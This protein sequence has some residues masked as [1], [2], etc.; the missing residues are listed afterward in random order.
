MLVVFQ[1]S[2]SALLLISTGLIYRQVDHMR[3]L[4]LG[5]NKDHLIYMSLRF[6]TA[7]TYPVFKRE[8]QGDA[9]IPGV[10][11]AFQ[12]P[13]NNRMKETGTRWDGWNPEANSYVF[14]DAVD[15]DYAET[16]GLEL[17]AGRP[18]SEQFASDLAGAFLVNQTMLKQMDTISAEEAVGK[19]LSSWG[20]T[21]PI[22]GVLKDYHFQNARS[23]IEPQVISLGQDKL[24]YAVI[25][26][27][28]GR[29]QNSLDRVK[30]AW[31]KVNPGHPFEYRFFDEAFDVMYRSDQLL[32]TILRSFALMG[33]LIACIGLFGLASFTAAQRSREIGVRRVLGA[34]I[35]GLA[36]RMAR[37]F[38]VWVAAANVLAWPL[39]F[40]VTD[41][42]LRNCA[43][44]PG[45]GWWMFPAAAAGSIGAALLTVGFQT[46]RAARADPVRALKYE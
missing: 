13:M 43:H 17:A 18:F 30:S 37:E 40:L 21:G 1:F 24:R 10:T 36:I 19:M 11:A 45:F 44:R 35:T 8:L 7:K 22:V 33:V 31:Q 27:Q 28:G 42:W 12:L 34:S 16:L 5:Y 3:T 38:I 15:F 39:A 20:T 4:D 2:L 46:V 6:D 14:Y 32:G 41:S 23:M 9:L 26:L 25:R 29:I